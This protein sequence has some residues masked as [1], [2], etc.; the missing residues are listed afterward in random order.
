MMS[1]AFFDHVRAHLFHGR[2]LQSQIDGMQAIDVAWDAYGDADKR[3][4]A[5]VL[6]TGLHE[7]AATMQPITEYGGRSY[8]SRYDGRKDLGNDHPGDGYMFRGR[9]LVQVTGRA[10]YAKW[11]HRT[12]LP[13][14]TD[15]DLALRPDIAGRIAIEGMMLGSFTG[16]KLADYIA[17]DVDFYNARRII[18]GTDRAEKIAGFAEEF[19]EGLS[20]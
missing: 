3:K 7:T 8:F 9:G 13:L 19:L 6:A 1:K 10:N 15:P 18:N 14:T 16:K 11:A 5:Y 4:L 20:A 12:G 17:A 2:L